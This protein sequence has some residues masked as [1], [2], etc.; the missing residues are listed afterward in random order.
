VSNSMLAT[1][2]G[3]DASKIAAPVGLAHN[4]RGACALHNHAGVGDKPCAAIRGSL[5]QPKGNP[6]SFILDRVVARI[7]GNK[8]LIGRRPGAVHGAKA[9]NRRVAKLTLIGNLKPRLKN[10]IP[11]YYCRGCDGRWGQ[12]V[13]MPKQDD[14]AV[15]ASMRAF[16]EKSVEQRRVALESLAPTARQTGSAAQNQ[17]ASA[18]S[19]AREAG[20][21]AARFAGDNNG[22]AFDYAERLRRA[23]DVRAAITLHVDYFVGRVTALADQAGELSR[24]TARTAGPPIQP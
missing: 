9:A 19:D 21:L 22:A 20:S 5:N 13:A 15:S 23:K 10:V 17:A 2:F 11:L 1:E 7:V 4:N 3:E 8:A 6:V 12:E 14:V 16:V 18:Q 24:K